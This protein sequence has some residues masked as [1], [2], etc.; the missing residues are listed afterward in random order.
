MLGEKCK[1]N[2]RLEQS[3]KY[4]MDRCSG[5]TYAAEQCS[6]MVLF[7]WVFCKRGR[8]SRK[9]KKKKRNRITREQ[10]EQEENR[11]KQRKFCSLAPG[12]EE[13]EEREEKAGKTERVGREK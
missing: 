9:K 10:E 7:R 8:L 2:F 13:R 11:K 1:G 12:K 3:V 5:P 6:A 4:K